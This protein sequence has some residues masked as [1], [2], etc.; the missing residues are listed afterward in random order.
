MRAYR[1]QQFGSV[2]GLQMCE[3]DDPE[4]GPG[5]VRMRVRACSLNSK[6]LAILNL[7]EA[8]RAARRGLIPLGD[9]AGEIDAIGEGVTKVRVGDRVI[10]TYFPNWTAGPIRAE[11]FGTQL[12]D[13]RDGMLRE[14]AVLSQES[15]VKI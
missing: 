4:P 2:D 7:P 9:G 6:D 8:Q 12:G 5:E 3:L 13:G 11:D 15:L 14:R 10:A 1:I